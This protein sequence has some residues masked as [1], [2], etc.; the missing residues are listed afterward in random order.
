MSEIERNR[1]IRE[2]ME[3]LGQSDYNMAWDQGTDDIISL[4]DDHDF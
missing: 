1:S 2:I 4:D 3:A